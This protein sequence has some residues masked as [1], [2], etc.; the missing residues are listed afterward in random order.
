MGWKDAEKTVWDGFA[1]Y[2]RHPKTKIP[3]I[4]EGHNGTWCRECGRPVQDEIH[5]PELVK[6]WNREHGIGR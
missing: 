3:H 2:P 6:R 4:H 1:D 5:H